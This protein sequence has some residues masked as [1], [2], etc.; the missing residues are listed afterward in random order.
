M[1]K[2]CGQVLSKKAGLEIWTNEQMLVA[3]K[4]R[5]EHMCAARQSKFPFTTTF[6]TTN[7]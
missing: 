7:L 1:A 6:Q 5:D 2:P 4:I 3:W